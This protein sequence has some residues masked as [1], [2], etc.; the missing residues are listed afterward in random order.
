MTDP[1]I[2]LLVVFTI[3]QVKHFIC[4]YPL[5]THYQLKNKGTY[6]H[7]GG[8]LHSGIQALG[9]IAAFIAVPPTLGLGVAIVVGEFLVHYHVDW[10]KANV[11]RR[12]GYTSDQSQFW[13]AIGADQLIH[14]LTYVAI[15]GIL[16]GV[17]IGTS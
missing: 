12:A 17:M 4:D 15:G 9:T 13:W 2:A 14:H 6:G 1:F 3:L 11:M 7:P 10:I 8:I 5:Q 16:V